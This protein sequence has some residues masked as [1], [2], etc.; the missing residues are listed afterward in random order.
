[1]EG[2][3]EV[4][5]D[6]LKEMRGAAIQKSVKRVKTKSKALPGGACLACCRKDGGQQG[7]SRHVRRREEGVGSER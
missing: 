6:A 2:L 7:C 1:M 4:M 3:I 5:S